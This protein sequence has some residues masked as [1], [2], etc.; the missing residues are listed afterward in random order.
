MQLQ[1]SNPT[2]QLTPRQ[3]QLLK[4][5][6]NYEMSQ[7][8]SPTIAEL[9]SEL[10]ITRSTA[11]EHLGELQKKGYLLTCPGKARSLSLTSKSQK[12]LSQLKEATDNSYTQPCEGITL[13]GKVA[14]GLPIEAIEN[15][16]QL[17]LNSYFGNSDEIFAL[18]VTGD[19]MIDEGIHNGD[20]VMCRRSV[21]ANNGQLVIA[22]VDNENATLKRFY[23]E[24]T[25]VRLQPANENYQPIY[26]NNCRIEAVVVG[27][28][29]KF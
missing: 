22:I 12:L 19:S 25:S 28:I 18:E 29:R 8:Y 9:A 7:C 13:A 3:L 21:T 4:A 24:K 16:E 17:S 14:A 6:A 5:I 2:N 1:T 15:K 27:L 23:K 26:S 11:F 10:S 20:Y